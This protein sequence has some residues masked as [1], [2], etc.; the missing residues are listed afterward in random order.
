MN[1]IQLMMV[2]VAMVHMMVV[3]VGI[4]QVMVVVVGIVQ[5]M[6]VVGMGSSLIQRVVL[7]VLE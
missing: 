7:W 5:V 3:V 6:V 1:G 2:V 4:V